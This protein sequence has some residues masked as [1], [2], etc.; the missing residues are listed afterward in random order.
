MKAG[1]N[2]R[3][4]LFEDRVGKIAGCGIMALPGILKARNVG[5]TTRENERRLSGQNQDIDAS[6]AGERDR[7]VLAHARESYV[8]VPV[9]ESQPT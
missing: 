3:F 6:V 5:R 7:S 8:G 4:A 9:A 2:R 1:L